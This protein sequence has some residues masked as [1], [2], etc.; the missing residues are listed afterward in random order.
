VLRVREKAPPRDR[1]RRRE[2]PRAKWSPSAVSPH[3][4]R[5]GCFFLPFRLV[6]ATGEPPPNRVER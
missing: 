3:G 5:S 1:V 2:A 6:R 4:R